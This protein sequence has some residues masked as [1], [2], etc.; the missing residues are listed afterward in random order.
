MSEKNV[1]GVDLGMSSVKLVGAS[2][3]VQF[4]SQAA[5]VGLEMADFG[6]RRIKPIVVET[7]DWALY[8]GRGAHS[9]GDPV[10]NFGFDR[11]TESN[12]MRAV[13]YGAMTEYMKKH[14]LFTMPLTLIVGI[15][16][17]LLMGDT[18]AVKK[19]KKAVIAWMSGAHSWMADGALYSVNVESVILQPQAIG[20]L[21]DYAFDMQGNLRSQNHMDA[22]TRE[23]ASISIGSNTVELM[24][25]KEN[26]DTKRLCRGKEVGVRSLWNRVDQEQLYSFGE[27][28]EMLRG[29]SLPEHMDVK[30]HLTSWRGE[31][32][33]FANMVWKR[34]H[35]RFH[36]IFV[37]GGGAVLLKTQLRG[38]FDGK[39]EVLD[40][41]V[42][43]IGRGLY[44]IGLTQAQKG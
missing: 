16:L 17:Q 6:R 5:I 15:P 18:D 25:T 44:K 1:L 11:L 13:L 2:G 10:E 21:V 24:V 14:G 3:A 22:L 35:R 20:A 31:I 39:A 26:Q 30:P 41:P 33:G 23:C 29:G 9:F 19:A 8:V 4:S 43:A 34:S 28:D 7:D 38:A 36:K 40:D 42:M 27:F 37:V 32:T 12:E